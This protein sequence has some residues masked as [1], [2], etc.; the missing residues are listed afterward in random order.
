MLVSIFSLAS[1]IIIARVIGP[2]VTGQ[3]NYLIWIASTFTALGTL[4]LPNALIKFIAEYSENSNNNV[5]QK[6]AGNLLLIVSLLGFGMAIILVILTYFH[7]FPNNTSQIFFYLIAL[8]IPLTTL[9]TSIEAAFSGNRKYSSTLSANVIVSPIMFVTL[10]II[11]FYMHSLQGLVT[12]YVMSSIL[13]LAVHAILAKKN[14]E[15]SFIKLP[16]DIARRVWH[17]SLIVSGILLL[18]Q[19]VWNRSE[20]IFLGHYSTPEQV[21]FYSLSYSLTN[22]VMTLLPGSIIGALMP[23]VAALQGLKNIKGIVS[24]YQKASKYVGL[25][26]AFI[27][28]GG[29]ALATP[30]VATI[31][32]MHYYQ[33]IPVFRILVFTAGWGTIGSVAMTILYGTNQ[34]K[35]ILKIGVILSIINIILDFTLIPLFGAVGA[36]IANGV[37]QVTGSLLGIYILSRRGIAFPVVTYIKIFGITIISCLSIFLMSSIFEI[38]NLFTLIIGGMLY[39]LLFGLLIYVTKLLKVEEVPGLNTLLGKFN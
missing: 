28:G 1:S 3:Y 12:Y 37:A 34:Q 17:Y 32:G 39:S 29:I 7:L 14:I 23:H 35:I 22:S 13:S 8:T 15:I 10:L 5:A 31:Y 16:D 36:S 2:Y 27:I 18:D 9:S 24:S 4:G 30:F 38:N 20:V 6:I 21:A 25:I 33:M 19:I 11:L 26:V